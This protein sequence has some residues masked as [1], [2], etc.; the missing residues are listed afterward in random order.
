MITHAASRNNILFYWTAPE[1]V[2]FFVKIRHRAPL[3]SYTEKKGVG[4]C[5]GQKEEK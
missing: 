2:F 4:T 5:C 1:G 3:T